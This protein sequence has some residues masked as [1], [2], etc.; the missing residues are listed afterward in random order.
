MNILKAYIRDRNCNHCTYHDSESDES[1]DASSSMSIEEESNATM[2]ELEIVS[3]FSVRSLETV[4]SH[5]ERH[6]DFEEYIGIRDS[7]REDD[8]NS[9]DDP[10]DASGADGD[11][12]ADSMSEDSD[13][14]MEEYRNS[15]SNSEYDSA[16][17]INDSLQLGDQRD[18]E[19]GAF[20]SVA[21]RSIADPVKA[22]GLS[23]ASQSPEPTSPSYHG[24]DCDSIL[25]YDAITPA[26]ADNRI[27]VG[28]TVGPTEPCFHPQLVD[29]P[30]EQVEQVIQP[31]YIGTTE[32]TATG[33]RNDYN[34]TQ[35]TTDEPSDFS[36]YIT[37]V[38]RVSPASLDPE[39]RDYVVAHLKSAD[40]ALKKFLK[41]EEVSVASSGP[42]APHD[43]LTTETRPAPELTKGLGGNQVIPAATEER[44][45]SAGMTRSIDK[46]SPRHCIVR[47][48]PP[49]Q[50]TA[51]VKEIPKRRIDLTTLLPVTWAREGAEAQARIEKAE[52]EKRATRIEATWASLNRDPYI[53]TVP[54]GETSKRLSTV[55]SLRRSTDPAPPMPSHP[56]GWGIPVT[57][58]TATHKATYEAIQ[59]QNKQDKLSE[60][61]MKASPTTCEKDV[62]VAVAAE[63]GSITARELT[64]GC[65]QRHMNWPAQAYQERERKGA[66]EAESQRVA[67]IINRKQEKLEAWKWE[68]LLKQARKPAPF[69]HTPRAS[70]PSA[71]AFGEE[72]SQL[73]AENAELERQKAM[74]TLAA[75]RFKAL[76]EEQKNRREAKRRERAELERKSKGDWSSS[77][78]TLISD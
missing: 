72:N 9:K 59:A 58:C 47:D 15:R 43:L 60:F 73:K 64:G 50:S 12:S 2:D 6:L 67:E 65:Q 3:Q 26:I 20:N 13:L 40:E 69:R 56:L 1:D 49:A 52:A 28:P 4:D 38:F 51:M 45:Q 11:D 57:Q 46:G 22:D 14:D 25:D 16:K 36:I 68:Q 33:R 54:R 24:S 70:G 53:D 76:Q 35:V 41:K 27:P 18:G 48:S 31:M 8:S 77:D 75:A 19:A 66:V 37:D 23:E 42:S 34:S 71:S 78:E 29:D 63:S 30:P 10:G 39:T 55:D 21:Q 61:A 17:G 5:L 44:P 62:A 32:D 7:D 74:V